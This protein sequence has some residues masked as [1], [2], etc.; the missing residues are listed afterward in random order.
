MLIVFSLSNRRGEA[1]CT[2]PCEPLLSQG[3]GLV[4]E[5]Q[6]V[7]T[8]QNQGSPAGSPSRTVRIAAEQM[9]SSHHQTLPA[10]QSRAAPPA[11]R[12]TGNQRESEE[13]AGLRHRAGQA[14]STRRFTFTKLPV[15]ASVVISPSCYPP[16]CPTAGRKR[17][18]SRCPPTAAGEPTAAAVWQG[19]LHAVSQQHH[20]VSAATKEEHF[21]H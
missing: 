11:T 14:E 16:E 20:E 12:I 7:G 19:A 9:K 1:A 5:E 2:A 6:A 3:T 18:G 10:A 4:W 15:P 17:S 21:I 13:G 8:L